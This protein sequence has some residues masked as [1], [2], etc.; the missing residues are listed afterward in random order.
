MNTDANPMSQS[1]DQWKLCLA[2]MMDRTDRHF[3]YLMRLL[4][5]KIRL[6]TEMVT[7][8][9]VLH[10]DKEKFLG[11]D[12][13]EHPIA[14]QLGGSDPDDLCKAAETGIS[15]GYD[16]I[17]LNCGCPSSKVLAGRFGAQMMLEPQAT[18]RAVA[19]L[20]TVTSSLAVPL[21]VK[22]RLGVDNHDSYS[23]FEDFIGALAESGCSIFHLHARKAILKGLSPR[24]NRNIPPL[25]YE[26][27]YR[28]KKENPH[29]TIIINGGIEDSG[30]VDSHIEAVD[31]VMVGRRLYNTPESVLDF[32]HTIF[33]TPKEN[34]DFVKLLEDFICYAEKQVAN[35]IYIKHLTRHLA[36]LFR[37]V[38]GA[39]RWRRDLTEG[40]AKITT[41][42]EIISK[43]FKNLGAFES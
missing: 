2:P 34:F 7:T 31:G 33:G 15:W 43:A 9:A 16:E 38:H 22:T 24:E 18:A 13:L 23:F 3:R 21:S 40:A 12:E 41:G 42:T 32:E 20:G 26:W 8:G 29:L 28:L 4:G 30:D 19:E 37:G 25:R 35:G 39:R 17:N 1:E 36:N 27:V 6:Y 10:G 11:F 14:L 5:R